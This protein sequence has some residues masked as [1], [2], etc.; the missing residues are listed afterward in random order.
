MDRFKT[1]N[2]ARQL[3]GLPV[4]APDWAQRLGQVSDAVIHPTEGRLLGL[5]L[6]SPRGKERLLSAK[7]FFIFGAV[8]AVLTEV[9]SPPE[10]K[11]LK[12]VSSDGVRVCRD[13]IGAKVITGDGK[14]LG[15]V[16]DVYL[17]EEQLWAFYYITKTK[18]Q[19]FFGSGFFI[20]G[21]VPQAWSDRDACLIVPA[22]AERSCTALSLA[23]A[24]SAFEERRAF[25][26]K[27]P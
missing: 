8:S 18:L 13:L 4:I 10:A 9:R 1:L 24:I 12:E 11:S 15:G 7:N 5:V 6:Q 2:V 22:H 14:L 19:E 17:L 27:K 25:A 26:G 20:A 16:S 21:N 23:E 3:I